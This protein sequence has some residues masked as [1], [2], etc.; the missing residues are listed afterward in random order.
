VILRGRLFT[1]CEQTEKVKQNDN[2]MIV[3]TISLV[4]RWGKSTPDDVR[5]LK[6]EAGIAIPASL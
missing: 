4:G 6:S 3:S 5:A 2:M 1:I